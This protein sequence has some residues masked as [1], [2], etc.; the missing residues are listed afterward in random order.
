MLGHDATRRLVSSLAKAEAEHGEARRMLSRLDSQ[1]ISECTHGGGIVVTLRVAHASGGAA[2][3][4]RSQPSPALASH[5]LPGS[6]S[7]ILIED[8]SQFLNAASHVVSRE[9]LASF[10]RRSFA[11]TAILY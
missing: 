2:A 9:G 3:R 4:L 10:G 8:T 6:F 11:S 7:G 5:G 1:P